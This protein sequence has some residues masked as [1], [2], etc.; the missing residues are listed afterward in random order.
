MARELNRFFNSHAELA[1]AVHYFSV[2]ETIHVDDLEKVRLGVF[3]WTLLTTMTKVDYQ[4]KAAHVDLLKT[5]S[6]PFLRPVEWLAS[7]RR[8]KTGRANQRRKQTIPT[9]ILAKL[10]ATASTRC[11]DIRVAFSGHDCLLNTVPQRE[12]VLYVFLCSL[13]RTVS[14][15]MSLENR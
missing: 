4:A 13:T 15:C 10:A 6:I 3:S 7:M 5:R 14:K 2:V 1:C 11:R 8:N 9:S 12:E